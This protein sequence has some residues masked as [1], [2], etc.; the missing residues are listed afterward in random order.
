MGDWTTIGTIEELIATKKVFDESGLKLYLTAGDHD[1]WDSRNRGLNP[2]SNYTQIL[3]V[4]THE[5]NT[6]NIHFVILDNSDIYRGIDNSEWSMV[7]GLPRRQAGKLS[8][9]SKLTFVFAHKTPFHPESQHIMGQ[10]NP[11]VKK[12]AEQLTKLLEEKKVDGF[13]SGDIHF[14]AQFKSPADV[15]KITT[16][17]AVARQRNF[18]GPR[19]GIVTVYNDYSW[20]VKDVEIR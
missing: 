6:E 7:N 17:G 12:Q 15:V 4:P 11:E 18:Q 10:D 14:F 5:F 13:F 8:D 16:I 20:E 19:F 3:G 2:L 1:L 9:A